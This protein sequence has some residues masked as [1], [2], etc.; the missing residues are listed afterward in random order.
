MARNG[1]NC[2]IY[3]RPSSLYRSDEN[4]PLVDDKRSAFL[5]PTYLQCFA[6]GIPPCFTNSKPFAIECV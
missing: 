2:V 5:Q 1:V 4:D 3:G 6:N